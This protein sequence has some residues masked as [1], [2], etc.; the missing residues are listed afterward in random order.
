MAVLYLYRYNNSKVPTTGPTKCGG[1]D[2]G[3]NRSRC[4]K[5]RDLRFLGMPDLLVFS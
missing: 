1:I 4:H 3:G 5:D 2:R